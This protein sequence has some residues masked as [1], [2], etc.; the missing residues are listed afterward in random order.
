LSSVANKEALFC[1]G[2]TVDI[3]LGFKG[4]TEGAESSPLDKLYSVSLER[5]PGA[6]L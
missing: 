4:S 6:Y 1:N 3:V 2:G 5:L